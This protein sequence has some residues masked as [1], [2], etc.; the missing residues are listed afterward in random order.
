MQALK[1][2]ATPADIADAMLFLATDGARW[3]TGETLR[4]DGGSR[5]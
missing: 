3:V 2:L 4:V 1:R 5:L